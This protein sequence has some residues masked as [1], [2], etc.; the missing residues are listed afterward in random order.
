VNDRLDVVERSSPDEHVLELHGEIDMESV[1]ALSERL[2][3]LVK[4]GSG[5]TL[6]LLGVEFIDSSG[7]RLLIGVDGE[8]RRG[9]HRL[10]IRRPSAPVQR[11]LEI[12]ALE[13]WLQVER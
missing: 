7:L 5:L 13:R 3:P 8:M 11:I 1:T 4:A 9:G 2:D 10:V 12:T 6:D